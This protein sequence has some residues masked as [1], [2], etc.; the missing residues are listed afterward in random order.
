MK[1]DTTMQNKNLL[2]SIKE[3]R[4]LVF[5]K[6]N[7]NVVQLI[8]LSLLILFMLWAFIWNQIN[9]DKK[10]IL[11]NTF[12]NVSNVE[13]AFKET[14]ETI[15]KQGEQLI[16]IEKFYLERYSV[17][18]YP[19]LK[20]L[21][22]NKILDLGK[23]NQIGYINQDGI[24]DFSNLNEFKRVDLSGREHFTVHKEIYPYESFVSMPV[25]GRASGKT[26]I[27][28][29]CRVNKLD[30]SFNGVAVISFDPN[31]F[32]SF[33]EKM[34]L[35]DGALVSI[36]GEEGFLRTLYIQGKDN[37]SYINIKINIPQDMLGKNSGV[38]ESESLYD[39]TKRYYSFEKVKNK[40]LY[41][42]VGIT[43]EVAFANYNLYKK[44]YLIFGLLTSLLILIYAG[45][46]VRSLFRSSQ[47]NEKLIESNHLIEESNI[48]LEHL[49]S[50][51]ETANQ[52]KSK[53]L[54]TMSHEIRTPLNGILGMAQILLNQKLSEAEKQEHIKTIL[55][56]GQN[57]QLILNDILDFSKVESG[58]LE[59]IKSPIN[60][61]TII[62]DV[63]ELFSGAARIKNLELNTEFLFPEGN[64]YLADELRLTQILSN[65]VSNAI[66]FTGQGNV[67]ISGHEISRQGNTAMIELSVTDTGSGIS[68][69]NQELL[70]KSFSQVN[71]TPY[72]IST[73]S[74]LGLSIVRSLI[75]LMNGEYGV[76]SAEGLGSKFWIRIPAEFISG[77]VKQDKSLYNSALNEQS[78]KKL[79]PKVFIVEDNLTNQMVLSSMLRTM[80]PEF[81]IEVFGDGQ[82]CYDRYVK[83]PEVDLILMDIGMPVMRGDEAT[84]LIRSFEKEQQINPVTIVAVSA[85]VYKE[86]RDRFKAIGMNDFLSKP[87]EF[88]YLQRVIIQ[89]LTADGF[90]DD[91]AS[92]PVEEVP[93]LKVFNRESM[94]NNLG[95]N[96]Q[97]ALNVIRSTIQEVPKFFER[98]NQSIIEMH[99]VEAKSTT[100]SLKGLVSQ[101]G[102]EVLA[103]EVIRLNDS[104]NQGNVITTQDVQQLETLYREL[105]EAIKSDPQLN[106]N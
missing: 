58:K 40:P 76:D 1:S 90:E 86:D 66:K 73:G 99:W 52:T 72:S 106:S 21:F 59:L 80:G 50:A 18:S 6:K 101:I 77:E 35:G 60:P 67:L 98:L 48:Q 33:Y 49:K 9:S 24:Y 29:S 23:F 42:L 11:E 63:R 10:N 16:H 43:E 53:F 15:L 17:N 47:I 102:G 7:I 69:K 25:I 30:G 39:N 27:Q 94:F 79:S 32:L 12:R 91:V 89:C 26:S 54:A 13:R 38:F 8:I 37:P 14:T 104:L 71:A 83:D 84:R 95:Q 97:L 74:G 41:I 28:L 75:E 44:V 55:T 62:K 87:I 70:F 56:S 51:A 5:L 2:N 46:S 36:V 3:N 92:L 20:D 57:L 78:L 105:L 68:D 93:S 4:N 82:Q 65:F 100:H 45:I 88:G 81:S 19:I 85:Y 61:H 64:L 96:K 31:I 22:Q 34:D 103:K